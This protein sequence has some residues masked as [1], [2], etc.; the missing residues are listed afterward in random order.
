[1][2]K[3]VLTCI[4]YVALVFVFAYGVQVIQFGESV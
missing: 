4:I 3:F 2:L 1:M